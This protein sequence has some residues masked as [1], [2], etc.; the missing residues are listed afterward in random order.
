[1]VHGFR[2]KARMRFIT[3]LRLLTIGLVVILGLAVI[4]LTCGILGASAR[5]EW[6]LTQEPE[7]KVLSLDVYVG[8]S[9]KSFDR[10][11]VDESPEVVNIS[12]YIDTH[13][14]GGDGILQMSRHEIELA[15][16]LGDRLLLGCTPHGRNRFRNPALQNC[17]SVAK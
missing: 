6:V 4:A 3:S 7:G 14:S 2:Y 11:D 16:P 17:R 10:V 8:N 5:A 9:C 15:D 12:A 13:C 1:M